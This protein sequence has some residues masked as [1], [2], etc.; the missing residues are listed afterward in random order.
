LSLSFLYDLPTRHIWAQGPA[1]GRKLVDNWQAGGILTAQSG[2]PFTV[3][4][5]G[6]PAA[7]AAAFGNPQ[8]PD[9]V[10]DPFKPGAVAANPTCQAPM[11]VGTPQN[12]FNQCAFAQPAA[13]PFGPA[14]GTEG[15]NILVGPGFNNLDFSLTKS[16][17]LRGE[18][19]RLQLRGEFF[20]LFNHP[21]FDIPAHTFDLTACGPNLICPAGNYGS[22]LSAN[23]SGSKPPRQ[24]Q[25]SVRYVF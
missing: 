8:R 12:W 16:I 7:S 23:A 3:V 10:G 17:P 20:N 5:A 25:L 19:H 6:S 4:L 21:N 22:I 15:R 2:S 18:S 13:E 11:Q 14:F 24:I 1:W 9:L